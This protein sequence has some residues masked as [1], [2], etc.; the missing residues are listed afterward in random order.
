VAA[1]LTAARLSV[2]GGLAFDTALVR[3]DAVRGI[4]YELVEP[5]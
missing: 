2:Q 4:G 5:G 1:L 3:I